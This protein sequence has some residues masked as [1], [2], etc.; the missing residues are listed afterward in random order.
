MITQS[1]FKIASKK[2]S[3]QHQ[4]IPAYLDTEYLGQT[5]IRP[6]ISEGPLSN[7]HF[8]IIF[9]RIICKSPIKHYEVQW[10]PT[11]R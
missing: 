8:E 10:P 6:F 9:W 3:V 7:V 11:Y 4:F 1:K 5:A 2:C